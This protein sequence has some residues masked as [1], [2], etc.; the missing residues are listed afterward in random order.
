MVPSLLP[1]TFFCTY[2]CYSKVYS[3]V[4]HYHIF[5]IIHRPSPDHRKNKGRTN[6]ILSSFTPIMYFL[7]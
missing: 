1:P 3:Q 6:E 2:S 7:M 4:C 5:N